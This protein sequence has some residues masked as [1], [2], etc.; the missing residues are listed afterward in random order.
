M[1]DTDV[2]A[3]MPLD[4]VS[5]V[6]QLHRIAVTRCARDITATSQRH[7]KVGEGEGAVL[8]GRNPGTML[9]DTRWCL[10]YA[11]RWPLDW[12]PPP[13]CRAH[14]GGARFQSTGAPGMLGPPQEAP[15]NS[16]R[17][18]RRKPPVVWLVRLPHA[19]PYY[20]ARVRFGLPVRRTRLRAPARSPQ[21][22][23]DGCV[24]E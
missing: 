22:R 20:S 13:A 14:C 15:E 12:R 19:A 6:G 2:P 11:I 1:L 16:L 7:R 9:L 8:P 18:R 10:C 21:M 24:Q 3:R 23:S 17:S 5:T 4:P